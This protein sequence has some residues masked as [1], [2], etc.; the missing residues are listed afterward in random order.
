ML[1]RL[2]S[3]LPGQGSSRPGCVRCDAL[4]GRFYEHEVFWEEAPIFDT[5]VDAPVIGYLAALAPAQKWW[6]AAEQFSRYPLVPAPGEPSDS[7][8]QPPAGGQVE[9]F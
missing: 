3:R 9:L 1:R 5:T 7:T 8:P 6:L 2:Q 4:Q